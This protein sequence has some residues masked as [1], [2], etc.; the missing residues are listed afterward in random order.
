MRMMPNVQGKKSFFFW[1]VPLTSYKVAN[2]TLGFALDI[3]F[4]SVKQRKFDPTLWTDTKHKQSKISV[5]L[6]KYFK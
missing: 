6:H 3:D 5:I 4:T 2:S 1:H